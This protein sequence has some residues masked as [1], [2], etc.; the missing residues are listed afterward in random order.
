MLLASSA[1]GVGFGNAGVTLCHGMSYP[2][3]S[4]VKKYIPPGY[5]D[6]D[7]PLVPHGHSVIV[8]APAVFRFTGKANPG[9]HLECAKIL[10][11]A[12]GASD[13]VLAA[14][15]D[16]GL[17]LADEILEL[18]IKLDVPVGLGAL[19]YDEGDVEDLAEGTLPQHRVIKL[20]PRPVGRDE[21]INLFQDALAG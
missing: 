1:A 20:S 9:R 18:M 14:K 19:G 21:I 4:Q 5:G 16:A 15:G 11:E 3:A 10:A 7:H 12:R 8:N 6:V 2:V 13:M 17:L